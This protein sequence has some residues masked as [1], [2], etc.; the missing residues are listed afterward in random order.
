[1]TKQ[2]VIRP[3]LQTLLWRMNC[4]KLTSTSRL[5]RSR[6]TQVRRPSR[7]DRSVSR[8]SC[9][10]PTNIWRS[11]S[12]TRP[13][14]CCSKPP[15]RQPTR[16]KRRRHFSASSSSAGIILNSLPLASPASKLAANRGKFSERFK[17][18]QLQPFT[19]ALKYD[20]LKN[21]QCV[22]RG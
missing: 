3:H 4:K 7:P 15:T 5:R 19:M 16:M 1:M 9:A 13:S 11:K 6:R 17:L 18:A 2:I 8:S 12:W 20:R 22:L 10:S 14:R 21:A